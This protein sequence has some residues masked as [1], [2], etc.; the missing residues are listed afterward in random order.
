M[1]ENIYN[2]H[3]RSIT[4]F[5]RPSS[6]TFFNDMIYIDLLETLIIIYFAEEIVY[7]LII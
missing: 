6:M 3:E 4:A 7:A 2:I 5:G 1:S